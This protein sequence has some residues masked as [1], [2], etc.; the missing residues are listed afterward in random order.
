MD[1]WLSRL[2]SCQWLSHIKETLNCACLVAQC[3]DQENAAVLLHGADG[4]DSTLAVTSLAQ[5]ILSPDSRT[6][7][8][9]EALVE[10]E[11]IQA[12]YPFVQRHKQS[13]LS[14]T[15]ARTRENA[16]TF[17]LFIDCVWQILQQFPCS[18]EFNESFLL[19]LARHS[20]CSQF[21]KQ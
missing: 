1:K 5:V 20:Y 10:R 21:G 19:Q 4:L 2:E 16:P 12:G 15:V 17:L 7:H 14:N 13:A 11:W 8:G 6:V 18:F 3:V 9:F